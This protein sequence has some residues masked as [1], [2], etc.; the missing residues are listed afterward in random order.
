MSNRSFDRL[1]VSATLLGLVLGS[2]APTLVEAAG[3]LHG[4]RQQVRGLSRDYEDLASR[5]VPPALSHT[6]TCISALQATIRLDASDDQE[7]AYYAVQEQGGNP[8]ANYVTFVAPGLTAVTHEF[9]IEVGPG[10]R[11]FLLVA[12]DADGNI[13]RA[14]VEVAPDACQVPCPP[15]VIC[16]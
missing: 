11:T 3:P 10:K 12:A 16:P 7:I 9:D 15:D 8:P 14:L 5:L 1:L 4:L 13:A 6:V 2:W